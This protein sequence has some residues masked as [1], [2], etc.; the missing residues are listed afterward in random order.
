MEREIAETRKDEI[1]GMEPVSL[2]LPSSAEYVVL[3]RLVAGQV[4]RLAGFGP[5]D[6]Y[7]LKLAVTEA[8][9]NV[10]RHA[11]VDTYE[12]EYRVF[13]R[14]V[15]ITVTDAGGGFEVAELTGEPDEQGGFGLTVIRN[16]V[17]EFVLDSK[18]DGTRMK[19]VRRV[20]EP[21]NL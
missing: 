20:S 9:T 18:G 4:G 1:G 19:M 11:A 3:A 5:E 13:P 7:D 14:A 17:D 16:L 15:E 8:V 21:D 2:V 12:V 10:I 6:I